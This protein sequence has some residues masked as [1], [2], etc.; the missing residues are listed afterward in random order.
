MAAAAFKG[1]FRN[2][3][4]WL[5]QFLA[6]PLLFCLFIAWLLIPVANAWHLV[7]NIF[8]ALFLLS[9]ALVLHA[10]TL[11]YFYSES[12]NE[13]AHLKDAF[14]RA[15]RN[16]FAVAV[17]ATVLYLLWI[18]VGKVDA[19]RETLPAY[20]R[21]I[22][23]VFLRRHVGLPVFQGIFDAIV[24]ALR[25]ILAPGLVLPFLA[26]ASRCGF[27]GLRR[28]G[29]TA[30][31][32]TVFSLSYWAIVVLAALLGVLATEEIME[33]TPDFRTSS[34]AVETA[35]VSIRALVSYVLGLCAW[36]LICS[37]IGRQ[38]RT[39]GEAADDLV[40]QSVA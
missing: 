17:C 5:V 2:W 21:S 20:V 37:V 12:R 25:W 34:L 32:K 31:K 40:R 16:L 7:L 1:C 23:P 6:N 38:G 11:N 33:W 15:V 24:F 8:V 35:S 14:A 4:L 18:L 26:S 36:M 29:L 19:Y 3:W 9:A 30:W 10:G 39:V 27:R 22:L 13:A 28:Q